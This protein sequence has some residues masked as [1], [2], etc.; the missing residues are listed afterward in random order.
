MR[1]QAETLRIKIMQAEGQ[2]GKAVAVVSGKGGVGKS[3]FTM[4]FAIM[5]GSQGKK[6]VV[7][8]MDIGMGNIHILLGES[9]PDSLSDYLKG[10]KELSDVLLHTSYDVD[11]IA[12]GSGM[13]TVLEWTPVMFEKLIEAFHALLKQYDYILFDMGAGA[14]NW[15]LDLLM[16]VDDIIVITTAEPTSITDAYSMMKYIHLRDAEKQFYLL[17]NRALSQQE[18]EETT[19]RL[20]LV[21]QR[22]LE[23]DIYV[24]GSL[25]EDVIVR[26]AVREQTPFS[27]GHRNAA[28]TKALKIVV[29]RFL[30]EPN[31]EDIPKVKTNFLNKLRSIFSKGRD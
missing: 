31:Q 19:S 23:K 17:C 25:P 27:I 18:G 28:I 9:A 7:V 8:D 22:F 29:L 13:N 2:L 6:V 21:M 16:S 11:Y 1:D 15:S 5:L 30:D 10:E 26:Q 24:L 3:N 14:T 12:G 20:K 4:N